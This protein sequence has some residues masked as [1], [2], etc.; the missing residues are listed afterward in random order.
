MT[1][2]IIVFGGSDEGAVLD[3]NG[4][5]ITEDAYNFAIGGGYQFTNDLSFNLAYAYVNRGELRYR[6]DETVKKGGIGHANLIWDVG[7]NAKAGI[8]YMW[9]D[10]Q[11]L[12]GAE[13]EAGR[14]QA[15]IRYAF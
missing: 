4:E 12:D 7:P 13:G 8:E 14:V 10:R 11:N 3:P 1:D 15:M 2:Q 6:P 5:L 9:G